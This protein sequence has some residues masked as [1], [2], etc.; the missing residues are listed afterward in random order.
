MKN[1]NNLD[2]ITRKDAI[3]K[4]GKYAALTAVG[5]FLILNPQKSQAQSIPDPGGDFD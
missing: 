4:M 2:K 3:K 1:E 5:T